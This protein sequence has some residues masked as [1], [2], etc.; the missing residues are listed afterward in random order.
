MRRSYPA[1]LEVPAGHENLH[2]A[3]NAGF[4]IF[5]QKKGL[6]LKKA[7][8]IFRYENNPMKNPK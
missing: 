8:I 1:V 3:Y 4:S 2:S 7:K 5:E 6:G